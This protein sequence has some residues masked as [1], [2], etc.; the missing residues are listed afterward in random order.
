VNFQIGGSLYDVLVG[1]DVTSWINNESGPET[2]KSLTH[3]ARPKPVVA[4]ELRV[5]IVERIAHSPSNYAFCIDI[6]DGGQNL[7]HGQ[8]GW[9]GS[10]IGLS[11]T[12]GRNRKTQ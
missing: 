1:H 11:K 7:C 5:N 3:F 6:H 2:L 10:G 9:F 4:K 8:N 12:W